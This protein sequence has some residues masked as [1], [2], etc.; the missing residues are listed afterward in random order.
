MSVKK[1]VIWEGCLAYA[2]VAGILVFILQ[3]KDE[4]GEQ[5]LWF[6]HDQLRPFIAGLVSLVAV[7]AWNKVLKTA[8]ETWYEY[9]RHRAVC[10]MVVLLIGLGI[11]VYSGRLSKEQGVATLE[12]ICVGG[13]LGF[14]K[15]IVSL[16]KNEIMITS[17]KKK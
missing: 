2:A 3:I 16:V 17:R 13:I 5:I 10:F 6:T 9:A 12:G 4:S 8:R 15:V 14:L 7:G 11:L 1:S